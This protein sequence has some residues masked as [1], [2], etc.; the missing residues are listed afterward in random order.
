MSCGRYVVGGA[1]CAVGVQPAHLILIEQRAVPEWA[2]R[3]VERAVSNSVGEES[4][5]GCRFSPHDGGDE[6]SLAGTR[7]FHWFGREND[8]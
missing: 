1:E 2:L 6:W 8:L 7:L 3:H 4:V 5:F